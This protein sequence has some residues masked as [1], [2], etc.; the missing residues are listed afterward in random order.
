MLQVLS[1]YVFARPFG[2]SLELISLAF[3]LSIYVG[4]AVVHMEEGH[5]GFDSLYNMFKGKGLIVVDLIRELSTILFL[6]ALFISG[7]AAV[8][9]GWSSRLPL[10][11]LSVSWKYM[12]IPVSSAIMLI[13]SIYHFIEIVRNSRKKTGER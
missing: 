10:S 12:L 6:V 5:M 11:G 4:S 3:L 2:Y 13:T 7:I 8:Q 1:R 9:S